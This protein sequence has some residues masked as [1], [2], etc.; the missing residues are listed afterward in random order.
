MMIDLRQQQARVIIPVR[1]GGA[2]WKEAAEALRAAVVDV[3][4]VAVVDSASTDGSDQVA[5]DC[6]FELKRIPV[7]TFNHGRTRQEAVATFC[8]GRR[9]AI[10]QT[11]DAVIEGPASLDELL[12]AFDTAE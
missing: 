9:V 5:L 12:H 11:Q 4:Q 6:G 7:E 2:R 10:F 3:T 8:R 1:N